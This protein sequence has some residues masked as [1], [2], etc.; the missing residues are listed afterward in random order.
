MT[1]MVKRIEKR[2]EDLSGVKV[3]DYTGKEYADPVDPVSSVL[4][5]NQK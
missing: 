4:A 3:L 2:T 5:A 1:V